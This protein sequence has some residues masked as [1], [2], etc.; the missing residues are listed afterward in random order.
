MSEER[1]LEIGELTRRLREETSAEVMDYCQSRLAEGSRNPYVYL[2]MGMISYYNND[3]GLGIQLLERG[4]AIDPECKEVVEGLA[5][6]Y[7]KFGRLADGLYYGKLAVCL[8]PD[9]EA[10]EL[11]PGEFSSYMAALQNVGVSHY[12]TNAEAAF[13]LG[14]FQ[15]ALNQAEK[16]LRIH[17]EDDG[18]MLL[19]GR[20][21]LA[22]GRPAAAAAILRA[23]L[24]HKPADPWLHA[25]LA[26]ALM[27]TARHASALA[28]QR[29][30]LE[31][32]GD[33]DALRGH[34]VGALALQSGAVWPAAQDLSNAYAADR[35][36]PFRRVPTHDDSEGGFV[37]LIWDQ[38]YDSPLINC[39]APVFRRINNSILYT[40][41]ARHDAAGEMLRTGVMR[42]RQSVGIDDATL[43]RIVVGDEVRTLVNLCAP[44]EH[45][46]FPVFK[47][48]GAPLVIHWVTSPMCD[49]LPGATLVLADAETAE[50]DRRTYGEGR[51]MELPNLL[52]FDFPKSLAADEEVLDL[53]RHTRG[54]TMFGVHGET[55]RFTED[56]VALW[57]RVLW[58]VPDA[59]LMIGG[60]DDWEEELT[61]WALEA[62]AE[63]GVSNRVHF[64]APLN[65]AAIS[66]A[67]AFPHM[68]D[69][70]LDSTPV[71][72]ESEL[73][74]DLWMGLPVVSLRG[75]RRVG[76]TGASILRAAGRPEWIADDA[77]GYVAI[78]AGLAGNPALGEIRSGL[79]DQVLASP[80][81]DTRSLAGEMVIRLQEALK[82]RSAGG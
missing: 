5:S 79:R 67:K 49:R 27:A 30:A 69:V 70:M 51:V 77:A 42:P 38:V 40:L 60:R 15:E 73:A 80:L 34:V 43:G 47:G 36:A 9:P 54:F 12:F 18:C 37:G 23:A 28:H 53:P 72:G 64:Q 55:T 13:H 22:L 45:A 7:T 61:A 6:L 33:D 21:L 14:L 3:P 75:D 17:P 26:Q 48:A 65:D 31:S 76:R 41:N 24:H 82:R 63:Y 81:A 74:R 4:H 52:A 56:T 50:I 2:V 29:L 32:A 8:K 35:E 39:V 66:A 16:H 1:S 44:G 11:L 20:A 25:V 10:Q 57:A 68:V 78:A 19:A 62:F 71:G 58:A 59:H 46:R